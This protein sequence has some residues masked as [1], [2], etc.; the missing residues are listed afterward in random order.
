MQPTTT[1]ERATVAESCVLG[2]NLAMPTL[3][4]DVDAWEKAIQ[5]V[6]ST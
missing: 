4:D 1:D 2:S 5:E 6:I 3:L